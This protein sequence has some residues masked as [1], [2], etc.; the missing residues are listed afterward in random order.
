MLPLSLIGRAENSSQSDGSCQGHKH[1]LDVGVLQTTQLSSVYWPSPRDR[2]A[3]GRRSVTFKTSATLLSF[4]VFMKARKIL[5]EIH[6]L[7]AGYVGQARCSSNSVRVNKLH[8]VRALYNYLAPYC[9]QSWG[10]LLPSQIK[11]SPSTGTTR[12]CDLWRVFNSIKLSHG[13]FFFYSCSLFSGH[14]FS[15][16]AGKKGFAFGKG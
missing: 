4:F 5:I 8:A 13:R 3:R 7:F 9:W 10:A 6:F 12:W 16:G 2:R 11:R 1:P 14:H 15:V